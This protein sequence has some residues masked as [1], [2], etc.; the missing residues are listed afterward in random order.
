MG[1]VGFIGTILRYIIGGWLQSGSST[2][3]FGTLGVNIIGSFLLGAVMYLSEFRGIF[4]EEMGIF[5]TIGV[6]GAFTTLSSFSYESF[7][8][9]E[10]KE[11]LLLSINLIATVFLS[12]GA[13]Y[14]GK[15]VALGLW[16]S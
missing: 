6:L 5:L 8:L 12:L 1:I 15:I 10:Q 4:N 11:L 2:F 16:R 7:R 9:F 14:L 3:P 13:V